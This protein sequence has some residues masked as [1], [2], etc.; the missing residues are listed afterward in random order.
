MGVFNRLSHK[1]LPKTNNLNRYQNEKKT[2]NLE[3]IMS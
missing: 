1:E 3:I 2:R